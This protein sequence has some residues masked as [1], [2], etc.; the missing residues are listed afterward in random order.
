[1][2]A[3]AERQTSADPVTSRDRLSHSPFA[4]AEG[5]GEFSVSRRQHN[6][7]LRSDTLLGPKATGRVR[8][9]GVHSQEVAL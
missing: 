6:A 9:A 8:S 2:S 1:M 5:R 7:G 3:P 4:A